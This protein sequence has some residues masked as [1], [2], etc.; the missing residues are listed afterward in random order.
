[1]LAAKVREL[2]LIEHIALLWILHE[3]SLI[4]EVAPIRISVLCR[5]HNGNPS[6]AKGTYIEVL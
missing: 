5:K 4:S 1:M 6:E 3:V 2:L